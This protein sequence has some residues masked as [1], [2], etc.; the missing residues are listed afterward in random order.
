MHVLPVLASWIAQNLNKNFFFIFNIPRAF[1]TNFF[2]V[3]VFGVYYISKYYNLFP[4]SPVLL[5]SFVLHFY[6]FLFQ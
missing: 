1:L 4:W 3:Y 6:V 5:I 2:Y